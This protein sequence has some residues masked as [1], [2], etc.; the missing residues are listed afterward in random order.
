ML[1]NIREHGETMPSHKHRIKRIKQSA[2]RNR[3]NVA[4]KSKI[5]TLSKSVRGA[6]ATGDQA[7]ATARLQTASSAIAKAAK[8]GSL[9]KRTAARRIGRLARAAAAVA[10]A[11]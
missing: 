1:G 3:R 5:K 6:V 4:R 9:H 11:K 2:A 8:A 10:K 7:T